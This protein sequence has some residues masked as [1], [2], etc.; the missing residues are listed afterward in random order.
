MD[1]IL[2]IDFCNYYDYRIGG[3]LTFIKNLISAF[4]NELTLIGITTDKNDPVGHWFIKNINGV[5]FEYF[6]LARYNKLKTNYLIPDR[7]ICFLLL[8]YYKKKILSRSIQNVLIQREEILIAIKNFNFHNICYRLPGLSS[9]LKISRYWYGKYFANSFDKKFYSCFS[10]V[11]IILA[12]GDNN[13]I[14]EMQKRSKGAIL[15]NS[16]VIFPTRINTN[17]FRPLNKSEARKKLSIS[18][19]DLII[20]TTGRLNW[21]KG[22]QFMIDCFI[23]FRKSAPNSLFYIAGE[24]EDLRKIQEYLLQTNYSK[25]VILIGRK[26]PDQI[27][28]LLN[29]SDLFI[30][31][32]YAEGWSTSLSE[33]VACGVPSCV[34]NFSSAK[35][36]I[37]EGKD[38]Y[39]IMEHN[40]NLFVD[41]ML[42][43]IKI[44]RTFQNDNINVFPAN[45]MK[46][47]LLSIWKME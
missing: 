41:G 24:G 38:G 15:K 11:K 4:G 33:A 10:R 47:D 30:M 12:T 6:A 46:E 16:V 5:A 37:R 43:A 27:S 14:E 34:T 19:T 40:I 8:Q 1:K 18:D 44:P 28:L 21:N 31:G 3:Q 26:K 39:V 7:L 35:E 9:K 29:A 36:I 42:K 23:Q 25:K 32:S 13:A 17:I 2:V 22:W 20:S 45:K